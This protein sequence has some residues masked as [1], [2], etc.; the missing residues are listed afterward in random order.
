MHTVDEV[1]AEFADPSDIACPH[2]KCTAS[3]SWVESLV[4]GGWE[5]DGTVQGVERG[6]L[7]DC[8]SH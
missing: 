7:V 2:A 3:D 6:E 4:D 5:G 1:V 8:V